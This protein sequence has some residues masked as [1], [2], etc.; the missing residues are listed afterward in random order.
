MS[1]TDDWRRAFARQ[2][3]AD[4]ETWDRLQSQ[5]DVPDCH[6]LCLLQMACEKLAKAHLCTEGSEP[7]K[8]QTSHAYFAKAFPK[9]AEYHYARTRKSRG[10][11]KGVFKPMS[12]LAREIELLAPSVDDGGRRPDNCEY[13]WQRT[14]GTLCVPVGYTFPNLSL[15]TEPVGRTM[16]KII[17][18]AISHLTRV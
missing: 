10:K 4:F 14:D 12:L 2:A 18:E 11:Y 13:P 6:K 5:R 16:L 15:L 9:I 7:E 3:E 17:R 8:L 1:I